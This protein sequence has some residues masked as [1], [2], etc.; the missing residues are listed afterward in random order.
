MARGWKQDERAARLRA[1]SARTPFTLCPRL[2][3]QALFGGR[4]SKQDLINLSSFAAA[5][6]CQREERLLSVS[7]AAKVDCASVRV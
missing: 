6:L 7:Q 5:K 2:K 1:D 4:R 3:P